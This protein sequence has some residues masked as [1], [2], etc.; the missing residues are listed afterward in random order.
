MKINFITLDLGIN[1]GTK[2]IIELAN[3]LHDLGHE[4]NI[5]Y[6]RFVFPSLLNH[7]KKVMLNLGM[8]FMRTYR[9]ITGNNLSD[10]INDWIKI[11]CNLIKVP[12]LSEK[13]I[14]DA[15]FTFATWWETAYYV[16]KLS[17]KKGKKCYFIQHYEIWGGKKSRVDNTYKMGFINIVHSSWLRDIIQKETG[18]QVDAVI[19]H[20]PDHDNFYFNDLRKN[21]KNIR[22]MMIYRNQEWKGMKEGITCF[23]NANK[24]CGNMELVLVGEKDDKI[25]NYAEFHELPPIQKINDLYNSADI[26]LF[27]SIIE[28]FGL[29]PMEAMCCKCAVVTTNVGSVPDYAEDGKNALISAPGDI[30]AQTKNLIL[31]VKNKKQ[32]EKIAENGYKQINKYTWVR[33]AKQIEELLKSKQVV[34]VSKR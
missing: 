4:V 13:Y 33:T 26:F 27:S 29:P 10:K 14:P 25:P 17:E 2:D 5:I 21:N 8:R 6:P 28:G 34:E 1:G 19:S 18:V 30:E 3:H 22:V 11:R 9:E 32:R 24:E 23:E 12:R 31:M 7:D 15:D 16:I 20:A